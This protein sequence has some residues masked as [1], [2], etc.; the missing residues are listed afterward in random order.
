MIIG[1][2]RYLNLVKDF[3]GFDLC[4]VGW[5]LGIDRLIDLLKL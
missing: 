1:G 3:G 4:V 5:G 2:G